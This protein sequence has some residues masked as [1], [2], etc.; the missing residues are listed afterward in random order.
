MISPLYIA[1]AQLGASVVGEVTKQ[2]AEGVRDTI[3][4]FDQLRDKASA[5]QEAKAGRVD[6]RSLG[7]PDFLSPAELDQGMSDFGQKLQAK[8]KSLGLPTS[9]PIELE[10]TSNGRLKVTNDHPYAA[11]IEQIVNQD[12]GMV[13]EFH[14]L[15][16]AFGLLQAAKR[17]EQFLADY[18]VNP[19]A[20]LPPA[21]KTPFRLVLEGGRAALSES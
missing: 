4:F 17:H 21:D 13:N 18:A 3:S 9:F 6:L 20:P 12:R 16:Q 11:E 19:L 8:L 7:S 5:P 14:K 2:A 15:D 1:G 10:S